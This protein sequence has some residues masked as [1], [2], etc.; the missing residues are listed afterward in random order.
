MNN[1]LW[2]T[3]FEI[4]EVNTKE[5][6]KKVNSPKRVEQVLKSQTLSLDDKIKSITAEVYR[7][8]GRYKDIVKCI[9]TEKELN[10]YVDSIIKNNE[11]AIDTETNNSLDTI[12]CKIMGGCLYTPDEKAVYVPINHINRYTGERLKDQISEE[13]FKN[14]LERIK[15]SNVKTI[16]HNAKFDYEVI[17]QTCGISMDFYWDTML[18]AK[19]LNENDQSASLKYQYKDKVDKSADRYDI[20]HLFNGLP[21]EIFS[22]ELFSLYAA[23]DAYKTFYLFKYQ[24]NEFNKPENS[25]L[26][27]ILSEIEIPIIKIIADMEMTGVNVDLDYAKRLSVKYHKKAEEIDKSLD[28]L[29]KS[30]SN[31][32][33]KWRKTKEANFK[34]LKTNSK[35][36]QVYSK[37]LNEKLKNPPEIT[38][39]TQLAILLYDV[40]KVPVVD[41]DSPRGTGEDILKKINHPLCKLI[42]EKRGIDK[43]LDTYIDKLPDCI[44]KKDN[45]IHTSFNQLGTVTG[46][47][48]CDNPN[49]QN[50]PSKDNSIRMMFTASDGYALVCGDFSQQEPRLLSIASN[51]Y[52]M[53]QSYYENKD[54]YAT[55][56][57]GIYNN[58]YEDNLEHYPDGTLY[59]EGDK[60]RKSAKA[61]MLG[62]SYGLGAGA[63]AEKIGKSYNEAQEIIDNFYNSFKD[64]LKF[65]KNSEQ[66]AKNNG[67]VEDLWGRRRRLPD[68][69]LPNFTVEKKGKEEINFNPLLFSS[70]K[71]KFLD[72]KLENYRKEINSIQDK[73]KLNSV[74]SKAISD[75]YTVIDNR[76]RISRAV[77]QCVNARIQGS[78]AT[79]TKIALIKLANDEELKRLGFRLLI[80]VHDEVIGECP[81]EN[82]DRVL[83]KLDFTLRNCIKEFVDFPFKCDCISTKRWYEDH[84]QEEVKEYYEKEIKNGLS[85]DT[86]F[87]KTKDEYLEL[88]D[89]QIKDM[90][91]LN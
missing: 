77:R 63:L 42:L 37:S 65:K 25:K 73:N 67:Y 18:G 49:L 56:A 57:T 47:F 85:I 59:V 15:N 21:Y 76:S 74:I 60:R 31:E 44:N 78:A 30:Y 3:D 26:K 64:V 82:K 39:P 68:I 51:D 38:S 5:I 87:K 45:K 66:F 88:T 22:P 10:C 6:I 24:E 83:E 54:I 20:E 53:K 33:D 7:I 11:V 72:S 70:G 36:E 41:Q 43:L 16:W 19:I 81:E 84:M 12:N 75:G 86:A 69:M 61:L 89:D 27:Y 62:I 46:R 29:L 17:L 48:S 80:Q 91:K 90:I 40:F 50:I 2:G 55:M 13:Q 79:M 23:I 32:I 9:R 34:E 1:S 28:D 4:K 52:K 58:K 71:F 8:L 14:A 35:G